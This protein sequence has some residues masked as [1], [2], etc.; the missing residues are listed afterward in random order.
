MIRRPPRSTRTDTLFPY[1]TLFR[2]LGPAISA[3]IDEAAPFG[4]GDRPVG[5]RI[6][7]EQRVVRRRFA[8]KGKAITFMADADDA[9]VERDPVQRLRNPVQQL[10]RAACRE[11]VW[12]H[13]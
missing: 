6:G 7:R 13:V 5:K 11:R 4:I 9:A 8:V 3:V 1:T 2:S 10:G 12:Q